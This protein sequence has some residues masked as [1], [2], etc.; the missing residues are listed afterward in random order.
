MKSVQQQQQSIG[1]ILEALQSLNSFKQEVKDQIGNINK[2][3][4]PIS[5]KKIFY[6][7]NFL[8]LISQYS[9]LL[10]ET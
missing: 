4:A 1:K 5:R 9:S 2:K 10:E 7:T 6:K 3:I 8:G